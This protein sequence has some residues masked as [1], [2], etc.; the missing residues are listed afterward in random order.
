M[1]KWVNTSVLDGGLNVVKNS[2][3]KMLLIKN[4]TAGDSYA[5]VT[6][7]S[8]AAATMAST[9][10]TLA[11]T[12]ART[13]TT[14][15]KSATATGAALGTGNGQDHHI[16]FTDGSATVLW[17]TDETGEAANASGDTIN[18]PSVVL[19]VNQPT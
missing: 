8:V 16:A 4:Y 18:F 10:F 17:V 12:S 5:T 7:N 9:D 6:G 19:T 13:L 3:T 1:A 15:T 11:G 14:A 2:A